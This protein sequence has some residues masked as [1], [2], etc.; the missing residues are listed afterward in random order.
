MKKVI[1]T[2]VI[3]LFL[4]VV[5]VLLFSQRS[6]APSNNETSTGSQSQQGSNTADQKEQVFTAAEVAT[7]NKAADCWTIIDGGVYD[8]T[9]Y[10][11][12]HP[13]GNDI[14]AACGVN[15]SSLFNERTADN[16]ESVGSGTPHSD[17]AREQLL[18]LRIGT[19]Q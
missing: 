16:G 15:G 7:H 5:G 9:S 14:V 8:L 1:I 6:D 12:R 17:A 19:L 10:I 2:L 4:G 13:G 3:V 18:R 11:A